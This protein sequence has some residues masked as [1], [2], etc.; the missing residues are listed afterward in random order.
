MTRLP[1]ITASELLR[2]LRRDGW[3]PDR[4]KG[5]HIQMRHPEKAGRVTIPVHPGEIVK[6]KVLLTILVQASLSA[7]EL[8]SL[9]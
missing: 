4:Q 2:A 9:L 3:Y 6:P 8:R 5:G 7:D 1:R